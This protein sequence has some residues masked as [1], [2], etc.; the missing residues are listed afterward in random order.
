MQVKLALETGNRREL[1]DP[2][3]QYKY[4]DKLQKI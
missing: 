2:I 4:E 3:L 1:V